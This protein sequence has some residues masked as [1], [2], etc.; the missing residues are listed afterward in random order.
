MGLKAVNGVIK[1]VAEVKLEM[2][3]GGKVS[4]NYELTGSGPPAHLPV[5]RGLMAIPRRFNC[6]GVPHYP[7]YRQE[8]L[9]LRTTTKS[10]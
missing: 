10:V 2:S 6:P 8:P 9:L 7:T 4:Q 3:R 1:S 5:A